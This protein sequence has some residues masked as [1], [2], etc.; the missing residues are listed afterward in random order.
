MTFAMRISATIL[1]KVQ[2]VVDVKHICKELLDGVV[3]HPIRP[4]PTP[5]T[6]KH[7]PHIPLSRKQRVPQMSR[8][9]DQ[10]EDQLPRRPCAI[11]DVGTERDTPHSSDR[12]IQ[13]PL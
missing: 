7:Y 5:Q 13:H 2:D 12:I 3:Y 4:R 10:E 6:P 11:Y 9:M 8:K 1:L